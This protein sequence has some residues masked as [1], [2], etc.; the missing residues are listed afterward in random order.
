MQAIQGLGPDRYETH[1]LPWA[2]RGATAATSWAG[3]WHITGCNGDEA[4]AECHTQAPP[5]TGAVN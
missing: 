1:P 3:G 5:C 2:G 4:T